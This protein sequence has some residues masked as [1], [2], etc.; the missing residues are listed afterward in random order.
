MFARGTVP[1]G[2]EYS[3]P[4]AVAGS[5]FN[6]PITVNGGTITSRDGG[7]I[8]GITYTI[9]GDTLTITG[10]PTSRQPLRLVHA[11]YHLPGRFGILF[12]HAAIR[13]EREPVGARVRDQHAEPRDRREQPTAG[14]L[15]QPVYRG[16]LRRQQHRPLYVLV[17]GGRTTAELAEGR[18]RHAVRPMVTSG[19]APTT[20][21][22]RVDNLVVIAKDTLTGVT[23]SR[24][25][26]LPVNA[27][28]GSPQLSVSVP[29]QP[30]WTN[31]YLPFRHPACRTK[32]LSRLPAER[33]PRR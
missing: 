9:N 1:Y 6:L 11:A 18:A 8:P 17:P 3:L 22:G 20:T 2:T 31:P 29:S 15:R 32:W 5:A 23:E 14:H 12:D 16:P 28:S 24:V 21:K 33:E 25:L 7:D 30:S 13:A 27:P 10:T 19:D 26:L 4:T